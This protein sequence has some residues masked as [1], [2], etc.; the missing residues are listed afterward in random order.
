MLTLI[1]RIGEEIYIDKGTIKIILLFEKDGLIGVGV[2]APKHI[3]IERK[4][5]F[6]RKAVI[7]HALAQEQ[8]HK[9]TEIN[10]S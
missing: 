2:K 6:I 10:Q 8:E 7:Q 9:T 3:D 4:E 5:V 1:R